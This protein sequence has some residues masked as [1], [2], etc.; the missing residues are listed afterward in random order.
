MM[1][2]TIMVSGGF[3]PIHPG[4][5]EMI[6][7]ASE[8]G[9][10]IIVANSDEWLVRKK[11]YYFMPFSARKKIL[12]SI[13][14]VICVY[15]ADDK[16]D[17]VIE[18]LKRIKPTYFANGGDRGKGNTPEQ[19][20]CDKLGIEMLWGIGGTHKIWSSS[21]IVNRVMKFHPLLPGSAE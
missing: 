12:E 3:D 4:H 9:D 15:M 6:S 17:T 19:E 13:K 1:G 5:I 20:I 8:Y 2:K 16:D 18:S 7:S 21:S 11:G 14:G 10:V